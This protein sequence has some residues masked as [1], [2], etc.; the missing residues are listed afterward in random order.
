MAEDDRFYFKTDP[1]ALAR[2]ITVLEALE[3]ANRQMGLS[4]IITHALVA[5]ASNDRVQLTE[6]L[7]EVIRR[8]NDFQ[9]LMGRIATTK[10]PSD[11]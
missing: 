2:P 1:E 10:E 4:T 3:L 5:H 9:S 7:D 8:L 11:G 6:K